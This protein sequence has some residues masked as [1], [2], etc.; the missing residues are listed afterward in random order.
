M[1]GL[2]HTISLDV[3]LRLVCLLVNVCR[4]RFT[5]FIHAYIQQS[6]NLGFESLISVETKQISKT[7]DPKVEAMEETVRSIILSLFLSRKKIPRKY[8]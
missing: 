3:H 6:S 4:N 8:H 1:S 7:F 5:S 2:V